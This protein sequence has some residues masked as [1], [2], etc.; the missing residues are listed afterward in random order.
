VQRVT[1]NLVDD[2]APTW[3]PDGLFI[4]FTSDRDGDEDLFSIRPSGA[5]ELRLTAN[6]VSDKDADWRP[7]P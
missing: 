1:N 6:S 3:S 7:Q 2:W 4:V 5:N